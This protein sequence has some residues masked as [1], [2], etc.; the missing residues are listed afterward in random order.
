MKIKDV[1]RMLR[2]RGIPYVSVDEA[3]KALF[4]QAKLAAFHF[5]VYRKTG[6]N[7]LLLCD[8][9]HIKA[10]QRM[11]EWEKI[12]GD[13]FKAVFCSELKDGIAFRDMKGKRLS[14]DEEQP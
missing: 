12:F 10:R 2:D 5:V 1:E 13:G 8:T 4:A 7:W 3:K 11:R 6:S 14:L 9:P